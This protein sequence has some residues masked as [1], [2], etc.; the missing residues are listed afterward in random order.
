MVCLRRYTA[1]VRRASTRQYAA[2]VRRASRRSAREEGAQYCLRKWPAGGHACIKVAVGKIMVG[3]ANGLPVLFAVET[4]AGIE[5]RPQLARARA[6]AAAPKGRM[7]D[8][9]LSQ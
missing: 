5:R 3:K 2:A 1:A 8:Q 4:H 6:R 7:P 9:T